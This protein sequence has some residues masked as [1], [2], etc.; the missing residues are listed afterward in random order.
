MFEC[1]S[2][3]LLLLKLKKLTSGLLKNLEQNKLLLN[4]E[5]LTSHCLKNSEILLLLLIGP[6]LIRTYCV[7]LPVLPCSV[8]KV[9]KLLRNTLLTPSPKTTKNQVT[10]LGWKAQLSVLLIVKL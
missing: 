6:L 3:N 5:N 10:K 7:Y 4:L 1:K 2:T 8:K 9:N